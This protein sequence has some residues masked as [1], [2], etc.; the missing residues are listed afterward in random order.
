M[1]WRDETEKQE[2]NVNAIPGTAR[3]NQPFHQ[4]VALFRPFLLSCSSCTCF[5]YC[6]CRSSF[7]LLRFHFPLFISF[8]LFSFSSSSS[9]SSSSKSASQKTTQIP[10]P[11]NTH[12]RL[13]KE[14]L[15]RHHHQHHHHHHHHHEREGDKKKACS[16][17]FVEAK[18]TANRH[19]GEQPLDKEQARAWQ[20]RC[21]QPV[22]LSYSHILPPGQA[23]AIRRPQAGP[24]LRSTN[25]A[26]F[27]GRTHTSTQVGRG[28]QAPRAGAMA[29]C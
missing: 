12:C 16:K 4:F 13:G 6:R 3:C 18:S 25:Q 22:L 24:V 27:V 10:C 5:F 28:G 29:A 14:A 9:S 15:K 7:F 26:L 23:A 20:P 21:R 8:F 11:V 17:S 19:R 1:K 2:E